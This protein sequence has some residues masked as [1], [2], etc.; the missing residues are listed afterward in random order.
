M[1]SWKICRNYRDRALVAFYSHPVTRSGISPR[2]VYLS[3]VIGD[4]L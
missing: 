1:Q 4:R 3:V 2:F